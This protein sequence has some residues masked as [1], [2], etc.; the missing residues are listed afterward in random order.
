MQKAN[1]RQM[2]NVAVVVKSGKSNS[3]HAQ[4]KLS[5]FP[6]SDDKIPTKNG[7]IARYAPQNPR[8]RS[9]GKKISDN[10]NFIAGASESFIID[11]KAKKRDKSVSKSGNRLVRRLEL[12]KTT[13]AKTLPM[14]NTETLVCCSCLSQT[15]SQ[16]HPVFRFLQFY[17]LQVRPSYTSGLR[18]PAPA[19]GLPRKV[20]GIAR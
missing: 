18:P 6:Q 9:R 10:G 1:P 8:I 14:D 16:I 17:N 7:T 3:T 2:A 4:S 15:S 11:G 12:N 20:S 19:R 5:G 13:K